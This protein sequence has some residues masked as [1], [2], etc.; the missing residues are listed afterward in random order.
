VHV[1]DSDLRMNPNPPED[2]TLLA[3]LLLCS[4]EEGEFLKSVNPLHRART[5][6]KRGEWS[7]EESKETLGC[8]LTKYANNQ[9]NRRRKVI[10]G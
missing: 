7:E 2:K 4:P 5:R 8:C 6:D 10:V 3:C 9:E 1:S